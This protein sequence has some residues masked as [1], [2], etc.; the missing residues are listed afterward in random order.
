MT[1]K[2]EKDKI[3]QKDEEIKN[4]LR[5]IARHDPCPMNMSRTYLIKDKKSPP[6]P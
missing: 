1:I 5:N 4:L 3:K 2:P 6:D